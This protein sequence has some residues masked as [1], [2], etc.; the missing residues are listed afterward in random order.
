MNLTIITDV[1][2]G[3]YKLLTGVASVVIMLEC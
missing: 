2:M 1:L 3:N